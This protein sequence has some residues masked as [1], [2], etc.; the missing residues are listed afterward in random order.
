[1]T[2][3]TCCG[4]QGAE[5]SDASGLSSRFCRRTCQ[6][7]CHLKAFQ[8]AFSPLGPEEC[9]LTKNTPFSGFSIGLRRPNHLAAIGGILVFDG[10]AAIFGGLELSGLLYLISSIL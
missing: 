7:R 3:W 4:G 5:R 10:L 2:A 6:C 8:A 1:M 9:G